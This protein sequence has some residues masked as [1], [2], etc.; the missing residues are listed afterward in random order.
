LGKAI[1][2][3]AE[4]HVVGKLIQ[5]GT[6]DELGQNLLFDAEGPRLLARQAHAELLAEACDLTLI[7]Q[8]KLGDVHVL[9]ADG[10]DRRAAAAADQ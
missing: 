4:L 7:G 2:G 9:I 3:K 10:Y 6:S 8:S 1:F 5:G